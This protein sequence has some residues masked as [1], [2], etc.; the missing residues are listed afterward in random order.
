M[1]SPPRCVKGRK[2][3]GLGNSVVSM[4]CTR[5]GDHSAHRDTVINQPCG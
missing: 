2:L 5:M 3:I 4:D 1:L